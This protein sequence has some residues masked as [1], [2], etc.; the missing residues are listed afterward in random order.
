MF[1]LGAGVQVY[2]LYAAAD[3]AGFTAVGGECP[4]SF[5]GDIIFALL[6]IFFYRLLG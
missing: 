5:L 3:E 4:V 1:Q 6:I 2:E